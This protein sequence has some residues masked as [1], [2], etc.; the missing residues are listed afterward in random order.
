MVGVAEQLCGGETNPATQPEHAYLVL[1]QEEDPL[2]LGCHHRCPQV[3]PRHQ[4]AGL[5]A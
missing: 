5:Q 1:D 2:A 4:E 3:P